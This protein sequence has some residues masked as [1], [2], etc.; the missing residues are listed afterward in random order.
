MFEK[1]FYSTDNDSG[2]RSKSLGALIVPNLEAL[3][4]WVLI[5]GLSL[6]F[7]KEKLEHSIKE[8]DLY[9]KKVLEKLRLEMNNNIKNRPGYRLDDQIKT[10]ELIIEPFSVENGLMTQTLKIKRPVVMERYHDI[11]VG[12]FDK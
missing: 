6:E 11:I 7:S 9:N 3:K 8:S 2:T 1:S 10:F 5:E 12:M 4:N